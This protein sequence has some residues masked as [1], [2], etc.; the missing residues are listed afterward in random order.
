MSNWH[1]QIWAEVF[2]AT[3][4]S[5]GVVD[6]ASA[7]ITRPLD[8]VGTINIVVAT[9]DPTAN[10]LLQI[11]RTIKIYWRNP[12]RGVTFVGGGVLLSSN[13]NASGSQ[14]T[15]SGQDISSE[16]RRVTTWRGL[17]Y[18][19]QS[20]EDVI[21]DLIGMVPGWSALIDSGL[22]NTSRRYDGQ[23]VLGAILAVVE[24]KGVHT[25]LL[26]TETTKFIE[27]SQFGNDSGLRM[28]RIDVP[29]KALSQN[30]E[31]IIINSL[32][33]IEDGFEIKNVVEP[34]W[35]SG[36]AVLTLRRSTRTS[37][38]P[39]LERAGPDGRTI[40]YLENTAS[41]AQY[42]EVQGVISMTD[43]PYIAPDGGVSAINAANVIYDWAVS[44]LD[45]LSMPKK[46]YQASG[47]KLDREL[48]PG[49]K[50]RLFYKGITYRNGVAVNWLDVD[51]DFWVLS[52]TE[53]Y[54]GRGQSMSVQISNVDQAPANAVSMIADSMIAQESAA[55]AQRT[56]S[57]TN[58]T[59]D[60]LS[61]NPGSP[62]VLTFDVSTLTAAIG[63]S[64]LLMSRP[65][66]SRPDTISVAIDGID[67]T[68]ELGGPWFVG[69]LDNDPVK[70]AIEEILDVG[71]IRG[72]HTITVSAALRNGTIETAV[73]ITE[74]GVT[75]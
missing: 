9:T 1:N 51:D 72:E 12:N 19:D 53:N 35:G 41:I 46:V 32:S 49:E 60:D 28:A 66:V 26:E 52:I 34:V 59:S 44:D 13:V 40:F 3:L 62:G 73:E 65:N 5:L 55:I 29:A 39:I 58:I 31:L 56:T 6:L 20:V 63:N 69:A 17:E 70:V 50:L 8:I 61:V 18:N 67:R 2:D 16:L 43:A 14:V 22:G 47:I 24:G 54:S 38:Y 75:S 74:I 11:W 30:P 57:G 36:A 48:K 45:R 37:P 23:S 10:E 25:R 71:D 21:D 64:N 15:W 7:S 27:V 33:V 4:T 42:G 68:S